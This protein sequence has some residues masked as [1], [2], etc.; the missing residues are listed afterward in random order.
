MSNEVYGLTPYNFPD[1]FDK[2]LFGVK[3]KPSPG[4]VTLTGHDRDAN[5]DVQKAKGQ[6]GATS[7]LNGEDLGEFQASF[8][9]TA[10][11]NDD[12]GGNDISRWDEFQELLESTINGPEPIALPIYHPDLARNRYTSVVLRSI[13]GC[14][15]DERGGQTYVVK[16]GEHRPPKPKTT[17]KAKAKPNAEE[18]YGI[19]APADPNDAAKEQLAGLL[20]EA[21]KP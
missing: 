11:S 18:G 19:R 2:I 15:H 8:Y 21:K 3:G 17:A 14:M 5:W 7:K 20:A 1:L 13:S 6:A 10:D 12:D 16:F 4:K 9:L